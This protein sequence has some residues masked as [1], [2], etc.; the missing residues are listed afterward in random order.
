QVPRVKYTFWN[1]DCSLVALA[2]KHTV[3]IA[4]KQLDQ[5]ATVS[6][7]VRVKSG[8][9][10]TNNRIFV[11]STLNHIKVRVREST[12]RCVRVAATRAQRA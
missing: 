5:L 3:V 8:A 4:T 10:D 11:Y 2:S 6:E 12:T 9:W 7:T 1:H